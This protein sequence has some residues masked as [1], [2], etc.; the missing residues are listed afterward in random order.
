MISNKL[1]SMPSVANYK[2]CFKFCRDIMGY[3]V[4]NGD[5]NSG[6][7]SLRQGSAKITLFQQ[8]SGNGRVSSRITSAMVFSN[9]KKR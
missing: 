7:G 8:N 1:F 5:E 9:I 4:V 3:S 2:A 6:Y